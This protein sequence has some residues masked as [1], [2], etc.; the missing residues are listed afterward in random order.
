[1]K[2]LLLIP[3]L[4]TLLWGC[5]G[6][7]QQQSGHGPNILLITTDQHTYFSL[8]VAGNPE[9]HTPNMDRIARSGVNFTHGIVPTP[10][11]SPTRATIFTGLNTHNHDIWNNVDRGMNM[12]SLDDERFPITD[13]ILFDN[14]YK[15]LYWG[16]VHTCNKTKEAQKDFMNSAWHHNKD[17]E[18]YRDF[19]EEIIAKREQRKETCEKAAIAAGYK[20]WSDW[21]NIGNVEKTSEVEAVTLA[22]GNKIGKSPMP[23]RYKREHL[24]AIELMEAM[25][26]YKDEQ[27]MFTLSY[28]PPHKA[29]NVPEPYYS[30][31]DPDK[32]TLP[33]NQD[34]EYGDILKNI[35]SVVVGEQLGEKGIQ[36]WL[37]VYYGQITMIDDMIGMVL[38][39]LDELK[40]TDNTLII[41]TSDHGDM[42]GSHRAVGKNITA[43]YEPLIRV[44]FMISYPKE[45]E[46]GQT[47][48]DKIVTPM[49]IMPT[50]LDYCGLEQKI[51]P[52]I[53]GKSLR[54]LIE[55]KEVEWREYL[56]GMR[57]YPTPE[58]PNTQYMIRTEKWKYW[59]SV[60]DNM[61]SR[62]YDIEHDPL[63]TNN[64][65]NDPQY[66]PKAKELHDKLVEWAV[67]NKTRQYQQLANSSS[68]PNH[69]Q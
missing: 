1:M 64:L 69:N 48:T 65:I 47:I 42:A 3:L 60:R 68:S 41:F 31:Y 15:T 36:E 9:I 18:C 43:F 27:W 67:E 7:K 22:Y 49:D 23:A 35:A 45:I 55:D 19:P 4:F 32:L 10:Y 24:Y 62:L 52:Q 54:P 17:F 44:P 66:A 14:G 39:K 58:H 38:D 28:H 50:I 57:D 21:S 40:L 12:P 6:N 20:S 25:E 37:R 46:E 56:I 33:D 53:D 5:Q 26:L 16:K 2:K 11:C 13:Q 30:M 51:P 61:V 34:V 63:E 29:W 8:G 59:W